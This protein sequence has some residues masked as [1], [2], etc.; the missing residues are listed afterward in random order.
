MRLPRCP[1][2]G[3]LVARI[4]RLWSAEAE[5]FSIGPIP[6]NAWLIA[7]AGTPF[8]HYNTRRSMFDGKQQLI[9]PPTM[10]A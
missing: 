7:S 10:Y 1:F 4:L 5:I 9:P 2:H 8:S 6:Q 3:V